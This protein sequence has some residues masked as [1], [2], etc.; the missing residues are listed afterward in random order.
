MSSKSLP[1]ILTVLNRST[2]F[3]ARH[4]RIKRIN[5]KCTLSHENKK[6]LKST[7]SRPKG[8]LHSFFYQKYFYDKVDLRLFLFLFDNI[9]NDVAS[10]ESNLSQTED[11]LSSI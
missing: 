10:K 8:V 4:H 6:T 2:S 11:Y 5:L 1:V 3:V 9:I 7:L